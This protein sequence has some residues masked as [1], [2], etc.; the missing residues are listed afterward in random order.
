VEDHTGIFN[1]IGESNVGQI[2][3]VN[4]LL[5]Y[6]NASS[7]ISVY[8]VDGLCHNL[9]D[10]II[11]RMKATMKKGSWISLRGVTANGSESICKRSFWRWCCCCF[12]ILTGGIYEMANGLESI[13]KASFWRWRC[14][15]FCILIGSNCCSCSSDRGCWCC[16]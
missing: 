13:R 16:W 4:R 11:S 9:F 2:Y 7:F 14:Y 3:T 15:C 6:H 12:Y 1:V 5:L 8:T 10:F